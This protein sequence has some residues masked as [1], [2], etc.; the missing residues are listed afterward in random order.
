MYREVWLR[1]AKS[2]RNSS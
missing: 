1:P 2:W